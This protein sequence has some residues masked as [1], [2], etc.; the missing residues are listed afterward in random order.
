MKLAVSREP[1]AAGFRRLRLVCLL[2]TAYCSLGCSVPNL[3]T[4]ACVESRD[5]VREFYSFHFGNGLAFSP[6]SLKQ[7]E[8]FLTP[9]FSSR[10]ATQHE[11]ADP[12]TTGTTDF[13]KAFR[14]GECK[15]TAP[16]KTVFEVLL[17]W[18]DDS[19]TEQKTIRVEAG[20]SGDK[21]L[22][23]SVNYE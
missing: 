13:P 16:D 21:W 12:F 22:I 2:L 9:G 10:L 11:G 23:D 1:L 18:R 8:R 7:R 4:P 15:E 14:V 20:K 17:F 3:E 19:R 6:E 5:I